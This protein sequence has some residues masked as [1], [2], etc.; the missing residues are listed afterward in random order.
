MK[1]RNR[2]TISLYNKWQKIYNKSWLPSGYLP[3]ILLVYS[4]TAQDLAT[5]SCPGIAVLRLD[6][7]SIYGSSGDLTDK[8]VVIPS[9]S[10]QPSQWHCTSRYPVSGSHSGVAFTDFGDQRVQS[11]P[12][13]TSLLQGHP[14]YL[15]LLFSDKLRMSLTY[16]ELSAYISPVYLY[17]RL[18]PSPVPYLLTGYRCFGYTMPGYNI[19]FYFVYKPKLTSSN[20]E[21]KS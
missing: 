17:R 3:G 19:Y 9:Y 6:L 5:Y 11:A 2:N 20:Y 13:P 10:I 14:C 4:G 16:R 12:L 8:Y 15:L 1:H 7:T 21:F 18:S